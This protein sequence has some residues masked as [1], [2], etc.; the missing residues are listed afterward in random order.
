MSLQGHR[1]GFGGGAAQKY[2]ACAV[3]SRGIAA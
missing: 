1:K 3:W 2:P